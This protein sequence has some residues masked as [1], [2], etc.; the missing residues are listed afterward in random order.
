MGKIVP[1]GQNDILTIS[2]RKKY[3]PRRGVG[4]GYEKGLRETFGPRYTNK[5]FDIVALTLQIKDQVNV[6]VTWEIML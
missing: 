6:G 5:M 2:I 1:C 4:I 3:R